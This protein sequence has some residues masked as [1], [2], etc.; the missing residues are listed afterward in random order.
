MGRLF[1]ARGATVLDRR[2]YHRPL[3]GQ[4]RLS[5]VCTFVRSP[6]EPEQAV[7][8]PQR[9]H[10][11]F[12]RGK[13][14]SPGAAPERR[15]VALGA[16]ARVDEFIDPA[17]TGSIG[18]RG[19]SIAAPSST[20]SDKPSFMSLCPSRTLVRL[21]ARERRS[22]PSWHQGGSSTLRAVRS[23][24]ESRFGQGRRLTSSLPTSAIEVQPVNASVRRTPSLSR[25]MAWST[26]CSPA[27]PR[28]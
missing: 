10:L 12:P 1:Q 28:P 7:E 21:Q 13:R 18:R 9:V 14:S 4:T 8:Q 11:P 22:P 25:P 20:A 23:T 3:R 5:H 17:V 15:T 19:R 26:P 16:S 24:S 2:S 6:R 27:A